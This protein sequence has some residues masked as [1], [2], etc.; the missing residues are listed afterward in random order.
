MSNLLKYIKSD[1]YRYYGTEDIGKIIKCILFSRNR[2][3]K[4]SFWLRLASRKN[5]FYP[6]AKLMHSYLSTKYGVYIPTVCKIGYGFYIGHS[7]AIVV[8]PKTIIG[9]NVNISQCLSIGSNQ[10]TP[11]VIGDNVYIGPNVCIVENIL[12]GSNSTIGAGAVV[13]K[14]VP[15]N[16][17]VVGVPARVI[18]YKEPGRFIMNKY[19]LE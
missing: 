7:V 9:N 17:T 12:I 16:S 14:D 2:S 13:T 4:Y 15:E 18:S 19:I 5:I 11:A 6:I 10:G 3:F 8:N 1:F